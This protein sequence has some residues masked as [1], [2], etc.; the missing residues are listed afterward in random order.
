MTDFPAFSSRPHARRP[1]FG[2]GVRRLARRL[3][4]RSF[5]LLPENFD[6]AEGLRASLAIA[7]P[8]ILALV[9]GQHWLGWAVFAA[10]WT[11]LCDAPG[12]DVW[13]RRLLAIFAL[14]GTAIA[15]IGA[16]IAALSPFVAMV[17]GPVLVFLT[18]L[19]GA[20]LRYGGLLGALLGVVAVVALGFPQEPVA[21]AAQ[22]LAFMAGAGWAYLL[23]TLLWRIDET[24]PLA[25]AADAVFVRMLDMIEGLVSLGATTR[26]GADWR[27]QHAEHRR[28]VRL[29]LERL[30]ALL[31]RYDSVAVYRSRLDVAERMF[32]ALIALDQ[33]FIEGVGPHDERL[34][35]LEACR[36]A[37]QVC[38]RRSDDALRRTVD[39]LE[40]LSSKAREPLFAGCARVFLRG[41]NEL[42]DPAP[43][44][45]SDQHAATST[46]LAG[47]IAPDVYRQA[48]RQA[49]ALVGVYWA[50]FSFDL[51]YP[52][53]AAMAVVVVLQGGSRVTWARCLERI[54]GSLFGGVLVLAI[55]ALGA[56]PVVLVVLAILLAGDAIALRSVN[57][58]S[59]VVFLTMLFVIVTEVLSPGVGVASARMLD[60]VLG[61]LAALLAVLLLWPDFGNPLEQ[62]LQQGIAANRAYFDAVQAPRP[63]EEIERL[64]RKAGLASVEVEVALYDL[65]SLRRTLDSFGNRLAALGELRSIAGKAA[66]AWHRQIGNQAKDAG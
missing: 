2:R 54:V 14:A 42:A 25:R 3:E 7:V 47:A 32:G 55:F 12:P 65:G 18:A 27:P 52:Y 26:D 64:R 11:C 46:P 38:R 35:T 39:R 43:S 36:S 45:D 8:L 9:L 22:A 10:F 53:W 49:A 59:F 5:G 40:I 29:A 28:S 33:S 66:I 30:H 60:N 58:T 62:R 56:P 63:L 31:E 50:A 41:M 48:L 16:V 4:L 17:A 37:L 34:E 23:I 51:G 57:Y 44:H 21:A 13:R 24:A 15:L 1:R 6:G 20:R 61:S 19:G